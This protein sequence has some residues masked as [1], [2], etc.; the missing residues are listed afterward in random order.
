[1]SLDAHRF[2][3]ICRIE[4]RLIQPLVQPGLMEQRCVCAP[5]HHA[6]LIHD[7]YLLGTLDGGE[8]MGNRDHRPPLKERL[9]GQ[10]NLPLG[11]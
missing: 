11:P 7:D 9:Q 8:P 5:L 4:L 10:L 6:P 3:R 1:M 2:G